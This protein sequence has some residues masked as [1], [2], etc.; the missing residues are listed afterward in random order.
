MASITQINPAIGSNITQIN[1]QINGTSTVV[2]NQVLI[3][4]GFNN[5]HLLGGKYRILNRLNEDSGEAFL[6]LC[7]ENGTNYIAKVYKRDRTNKMDVS[8]L[9]MKI[10][11]PYISKIIDFFV[12]NDLQVEILP[13]YTRG[14]L[15]GHV[16]DE[17]LLKNTIIP[18]LNEGL[19]VLHNHGI[20]HKDIKPSNIMWNDNGKDI[21]IIDFGISSL[22][23]NESFIVT[24]TGLTLGYSAPETLKKIISPLS[25]YYSL[26]ITIYE[27]L[28]G[29]TPYSGMSKEELEKYF[30]IQNI[31]IPPAASKEFQDL[32]AALTYFDIRNFSDPNNP[33]CRWGYEKV[34]NWCDGV[35]QVVPGTGFGFGAGDMQ[36]YRFMGT[37]YNT[38][39]E[40]TR[41]LAQQWEEG[42]A[43][44]L[45]GELAKHFKR[46]DI[47][48]A[49]ALECLQQS[50]LEDTEQEDVVFWKSLYEINYGTTEFYWKNIYLENI[51]AVGQFV[52]DGFKNNNF[53]AKRQVEEWIVKGV[54]KQYLE[55]KYPDNKQAINT[56]AMIS[57]E[58]LNTSDG[59]IKKK[60]GFLLGYLLDKNKELVVD[61]V[62][63]QNIEEL[64][65]YVFY[66]KN[67]SLNQ[68]EHFCRKMINV[69]G[70][71]LP[72]FE[73]WLIAK[74][75]QEI[76]F[77]WKNMMNY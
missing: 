60:N 19:K 15:Q 20:V 68:F 51:Y 49:T 13:H 77:Q 75:K 59:N 58:Y 53:N 42:K 2:N 23:D 76:L 35:Q 25:D 1:N 34:K 9:L 61:E 46:F 71:L 12:E 43:E 48:T 57:E 26:G 65:N 6:Y 63:F 44:M 47:N 40:L 50:Y 62:K 14:S 67:K 22:L 16:L 3:T 10:D 21:V 69:D 24:Q 7:E 28:F 32:L 5:G 36:A 29:N 11:C 37:T 31:P 54:I 27:L 8:E 38:R 45:R 18:E 64:I 72:Q 33:H 30:S 73:A 66:V 55:L 70:G 4:V 41:A 17:Q 39:E 56:L 52:L 74:G